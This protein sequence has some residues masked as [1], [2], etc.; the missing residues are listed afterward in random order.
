MSGLVRPAPALARPSAV[1]D[2]GAAVPRPLIRL[3]WLLPIL[4]A[5][6][7]FV[8]ARQQ[9]WVPVSDGA[10]SAV[11]AADLL[12]GHFSLLGLPASISEFAPG[13][14][15]FHP[16]PLQF[17]ALAP[18]V[19]L[20]GAQ[21]GAAVG[22]LAINTGASMGAIRAAARA[23][24]PRI[25][26]LVAWLT[27]FVGTT[28]WGPSH[29]Y[30]P[31]NTMLPALPMLCALVLAW[32]L[33]CG[34]GAM[35]PWA[36][37]V[38]SFCI[39]THVV[40]A[41]PLAATLGPAVVVAIGPPR[42]RPAGATP[43]SARRLMVSAGIGLALWS[44]PLL[45]ALLHRGGN[46][47]VLLSGTSGAQVVGAKGFVASFAQVVALP[48]VQ[49]TSL[50]G[51]S[52]LAG[53]TVLALLPLG[54]AVVLAR[55]TWRA[56]DPVTRR[57]LAVGGAALVAAGLTTALLPDEPLKSGQM[58]FYKVVWPFVWT[59]LI[60]GAIET[61][62]IRPSARVW[63]RVGAAGITLALVIGACAP[64][65]IRNDW[66]PDSWLF[67]A[68]PAITADLDGTLDPG[69]VYRM[70]ARGGARYLLLMY[71]VIA[72]LDARGWD[73]A[74]TADRRTNYGEDRVLADDRGGVTDLIIQSPEVRAPTGARLVASF[75]P[76]LDPKAVARV[77]RELKRNAAAHGSIRLTS[78]GR[79]LLGDTLLGRR[80]IDSRTVR[81]IQRDPDRLL[82]LPASDLAALYRNDWVIDPPIPAELRAAYRQVLGPT[83]VDVWAVD[84]G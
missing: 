42:W 65:S 77:E 66:D 2:S 21:T 6:A 30:D 18:T 79:H 51:D 44:G 4:P 37:I 13:P 24:R 1:A 54:A 17:W 19:G 35:L 15:R 57:L 40:Y 22:A 80:G 59:G 71:G 63:T 3:A 46:L 70:Q 29:L 23:G 56:H 41:I 31:F 83:P 74:V 43:P 62:T 16:G 27:L 75:R 47:R 67:D 25:T 8:A 73:I 61:W 14:M 7:S 5:I 81:E 48:P 55:R 12:R 9:G 32:R 52:F 82:A 38:A 34:D 11:R 58:T 33:L 36:V 84:H 10:V 60:G 69:A 78:N 72:G 49:F 68:T 76:D 45:D 20:L 39:Q 26:L 53:V 50:S 28:V 64:F